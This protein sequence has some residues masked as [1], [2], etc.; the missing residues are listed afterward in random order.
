MIELEQL[1]EARIWSGFEFCRWRFCSVE[2]QMKYGAWKETVSGLLGN[3]SAGR[4][5]WA[6]DWW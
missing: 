2:R 4:I 5:C 6:F 3:F 1:V